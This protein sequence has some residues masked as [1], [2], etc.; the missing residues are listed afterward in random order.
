[1]RWLLAIV[2]WIV[3]TAILAPVCFVAVIILAGPHS[4]M[5]PSV[6]QPAVLLA[7]WIV[8]LAAPFWAARKV[9]Q[10]LH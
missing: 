8:V 5:L 6:I 7:G 4:S 2:T 1:V 10:R 9:W 3:S